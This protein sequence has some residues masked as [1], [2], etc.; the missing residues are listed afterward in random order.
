MQVKI[1]AY[2]WDA[3]CYSLEVYQKPLNEHDFERIVGRIRYYCKDDVS[4]LAVFSTTESAT[5]KQIVNHT[6]KRGRPR[7]TVVGEKTDG[8]IH[9]AFVGTKE[10][11]AYTVTQ[12]LKKNINKMFGKNICCVSSKGK[13]DHAYNWISYCLKQGDVTRTGGEFDFR[14]INKKDFF[15]KNSGT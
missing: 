4:W 8:H 15:C 11:S 6:G 5:A 14:G 2:L 7:K 3:V 9:T 12:K 13:A 1:N 10:K